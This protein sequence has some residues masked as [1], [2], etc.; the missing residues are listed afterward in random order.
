MYFIGLARPRGKAHLWSEKSAKPGEPC[1]IAP[2]GVK[3]DADRPVPLLP[4]P[5]TLL[6]AL[7][8]G[9]VSCRGCVRHSVS[10]HVYC[11][12]VS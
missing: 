11:P 1:T 6:K 3:A 4:S 8:T 2:C 10:W 9:L 7:E 5:L 12:W